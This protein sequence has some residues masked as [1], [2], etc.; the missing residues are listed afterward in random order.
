L[1]VSLGFH[2]AC[3]GGKIIVSSAGDAYDVQDKGVQNRK[4]FSK[5]M[6]PLRTTI[7]PT[8][9][10]KITT[11]QQWLEHPEKLWVHRA[12]FQIHLWVGMVAALY[13]FV[14]S[15]SG[16]AIVFRDALEGSGNPRSHVVR[17]VEWLVDLH[18]NLL[19]GRTGRAL[20][21]IG[22]LCLTLL[23]VTGIVIWWPGIAHWRR[24]L[25]VHWKLGFARFSWDLHN[26]LGFWC[27]LFVLV[28]GISGIYFA[29]PNL[30]NPLV[31]F[32]KFSGTEGNVQFGDLALLWLS[33]LH[34]GR[35]GWFTEGLWTLVGF[36]LAV[37][38]FTGVFMCCHRLIVRK[39]A[40]L[41][42]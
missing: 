17:V 6:G 11:W 37:L 41:P 35:F 14:M 32:P 31:G 2:R 15:V 8:H 13:L 34:F 42:M 33:N 30:F 12:I 10:T 3:S 16:S 39:R 23:C 18:E 1:A 24:S 21:G 20:N 5:I 28:W 4:F 40:P 27:L 22:A 9:E 38:S 29:F 7:L 36:V 19:L 25:S 26:T